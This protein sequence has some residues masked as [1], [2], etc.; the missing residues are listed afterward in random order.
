MTKI[1]I[2]HDNINEAKTLKNSLANAGY[3]AEISDTPAD[4]YVGAHS[5]TPA[6]P[7]ASVNTFVF[8]GLSID[9]STRQIIAN[10]R[11]VHLT[12]TEFRIVEF[13]AKNHN[14]VFTHEEIINEVW[15]YQKSDNQALRVNI[16]NI[17]RKIEENPAAPHY[18]LT[19]PGVGYFM[20]K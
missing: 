17:R 14:V 15:G 10:G 5:S 8:D 16:A 9:F 3:D 11:K 6:H 13:L 12:P 2:F 4:T 18:I 19:E 1:V 7:N 20:N